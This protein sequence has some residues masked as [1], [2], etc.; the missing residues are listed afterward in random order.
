M[1]SH[2]NETNE[3][4]EKIAFDDAGTAQTLFGSGSVNLKLVSEETGVELHARGNEVTLVGRGD[5]V[6]LTRALLEQL[7]GFAKRGTALG[8]ED[9]VRAARVLRGDR[10]AD[11]REIFSDMVLVTGRARPITPKGLAQ[12]RYVDA[13]RKHDIV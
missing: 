11:L 7:Y 6:A 2:V 3:I 8:S 5:D 13:I 9:V 4:K 1:K 12:K 10:T